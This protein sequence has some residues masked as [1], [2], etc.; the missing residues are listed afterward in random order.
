MKFLTWF[1]GI[2]VG[3]I[4]AG[5]VCALSISLDKGEG[6]IYSST[7]IIGLD[8][9]VGLEYFKDSDFEDRVEGLYAGY[10]AA[11]DDP[12]TAYLTADE[13]ISYL[14]A[15]QGIVQNV[16]IQFTWGITNQYLV[17]TNVQV[18]SPA[19]LAGIV[20]GDRI[21][22]LDDTLAMGS[23][24]VDIY[25]KLTTTDRTPVTYHI[26]KSDGSLQ[27][28]PLTIAQLPVPVV[29]KQVLEGN[30]DYIK[31]NEFTNWTVDLDNGIIDLRYI[32]NVTIDEAQWLC[33]LF[34]DEGEI[35]T[36]VDK[37]GTEVVYNATPGK[38]TQDVA[39]LIGNSTVGVIEAAIARLK[40]LENIYI[41]GEKTHGSGM[42]NELI[43]LA[44]G[45]ALLVATNKIFVDGTSVS[46]AAVEP[47]YEVRQGEPYTLELVTT[48]HKN[49]AKDDP[50]QKAIELIR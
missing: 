11:L 28:I 18:D 7:K 8:R 34:L 31:P 35:F 39:I 33:D 36:T 41:V 10:V 47:E 3:T 12:N 37:H 6:D 17:V 2:I 32:T 27:A 50:L 5:T 19:A 30:I 25:K 15:Q 49:L 44:D 13:K 21:I 1:S 42:T 48:G 16:G 14:Q 24:E 9:I 20:T 4:A 40:P 43:E 23:N 29:E 38:L 22:Q 46:D 45:S 26:Q